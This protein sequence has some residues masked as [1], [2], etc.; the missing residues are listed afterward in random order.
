MY[1]DVINNANN[2]NSGA[3]NNTNSYAMQF[4]QFKKLNKKKRRAYAFSTVGT[5]DYIAPEVFT[6]E[7]YGPEVDW[8]SLGIIMFEMMIGYPPFFSDTSKETCNKILH[9]K[10]YL[11]IPPEANISKEAIDILKELIT[12]VNK[13]L[14]YKGADEIKRH[15]FFKGIDW[16]NIKETMTP[17]FVP[18]LISDYD[19]RYFENF[20]EDEPF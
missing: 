16:E 5:P 8:W 13:R 10:D 9:W 18:E 6:R 4:N 15:P 19:T 3:K 2:T 1:E 11:A 7:G 17:P 20:E 12:D 14:G